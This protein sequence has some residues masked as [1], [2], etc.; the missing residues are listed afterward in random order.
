GAYSEVI[1]N[2]RRRSLALDWRG[3]FFVGLVAG[4]AAFALIAGGP[5]FHG[6]GW[7]TDTFHGSGQILIAGILLVAGVLIGFGAKIAGGCTSGN[8]L[9][10]SSML[11]PASLAATAT[12]FATAIAV[13]FL[14]K[15]V[16]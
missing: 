11:S 7:L 1:D 6:Y 2:V 13:S 14:I 12:F 8:G 4:G 3:W 16:I 5:D 15:V 10:G 9:S